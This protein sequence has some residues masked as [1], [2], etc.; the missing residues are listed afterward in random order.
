MAKVPYALRLNHSRL[1]LSPFFMARVEMNAFAT[2]AA[3]SEAVR[4]N[5]TSI[6]KSYTLD[7]ND[8]SGS[9]GDMTGMGGS[10]R[11]LRVAINATV[12]SPAHTNTTGLIITIAAP[13]S[14]EAWRGRRRQREHNGHA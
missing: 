1:T 4:V 3:R 6:N 11:L 10:R 13:P 2:M 12:E 8:R 7:T 9:K 14:Q 5:H